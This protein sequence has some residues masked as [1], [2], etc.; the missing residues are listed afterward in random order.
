MERWIRLAVVG[1]VLWLVVDQVWPHVRGYLVA[2][3][4]LGL[5]RSGV[6]GPG[7]AGNAQRAY[8]VFL[9]GIGRFSATPLD[10]RAWT[11]FYD[12]IKQVE[13]DAQF[14]C[15]CGSEECR[16]GSQALDRLDSLLQTYDSGLRANRPPIDSPRELEEIQDLITQAR[17]SLP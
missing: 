3:K 5:A 4:S 2:P 17:N 13:G 9:D 8:D 14:A 10:E 16:L 12:R 6:A 1:V 7:C 15:G 11:A